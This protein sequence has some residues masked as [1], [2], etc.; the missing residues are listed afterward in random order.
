MSGHI[1]K[2]LEALRGVA[3]EGVAVE[4]VSVG[5]VWLWRGVSVAAPLYDQPPYG[6]L[7]FY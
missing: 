5:R 4:G 1:L 2:L 3:V 6:L 7:K